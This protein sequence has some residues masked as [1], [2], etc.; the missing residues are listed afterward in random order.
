MKNNHKGN[1]KHE[2]HSASSKTSRREFLRI[3]G[4][5]F[6]GLT[7]AQFVPWAIPSAWA[8]NKKVMTVLGPVDASK[9]GLQMR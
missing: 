9:I 4:L 5:S 3:A 6:G 1:K 8:T 7:A 2:K